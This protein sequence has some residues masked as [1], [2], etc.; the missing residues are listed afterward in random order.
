MALIE[1]GLWR[2]FEDFSH[3]TDD[4]D[5]FLTRRQLVEWARGRLLHACGK[6]Y[7]EATVAC[8]TIDP[9]DSEVTL[10]KQRELCARI[11]AE[12]AQCNA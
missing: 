10:A 2:K 11:A 7:T 8:L 1:I 9:E 5:P 4:E 12:L 3:S 6:I